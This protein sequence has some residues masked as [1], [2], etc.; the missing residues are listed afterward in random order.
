MS[1]K[2]AL[3]E[4]YTS[5]GASDGMTDERMSKIMAHGTDASKWNE[6]DIETQ[7]GRDAVF[8]MAKE[9][10]EALRKSTSGARGN[11]RTFCRWYDGRT[12]ADLVE[13][14]AATG[15]SE[16][17]AHFLFSSQ[18]GAVPRQ[19]LIA[20]LVDALAAIIGKQRP[21]P[22]TVSRGGNWTA[23]RVTEQLNDC[24]KATY[25]ESGIY[26]VAPD[27]VI[28]ALVCGTAA[29]RFERGNSRSFISTGDV[30]INAVRILPWQV[31]VDDNPGSPIDIPNEVF[32]DRLV[33]PMQL[34][35]EHPSLEEEILEID[36]RGSSGSRGDVIISEGWRMYMG[37]L[38]YVKFC[39]KVMFHCE[40]KKDSCIPV[41]FL[42]FQNPRSGF[43]G[44]SLTERV[45]GK[46]IRIDELE[47]FIAEMQRRHVRP[48]AF[49]DPNMGSLKMSKVA[50]LDMDTVELPGG[51][52]PTIHVPHVISP[53]LY[54]QI[55]RIVD[56]A[57]QETG[58]SDFSTQS[59]IPGGIETGPAVREVAFKNT[60][61]HNQFAMRYENL[62]MAA[63]KHIISGHIA[64]SKE[65]KGKHKVYFRRGAG[66]MEREW[67]DLTKDGIR[68]TV[69][70]EESA[71][72]TLSPSF[73]T[74]T[75]LG[76][77]QMGL[78]RGPAETRKLIANPD[79]EG[80]NK[81]SSSSHEDEAMFIIDE[82]SKGNR[83]VPDQFM[84]M[85]VIIPKV[86]SAMAL[87][88]Q[89]KVQQ[90]TPEIYALFVE[91]IDGAIRIE[92]G[93]AA[94]AQA[95][96]MPTD[97]GMPV[98]NVSRAAAQGLNA[99]LSGGGSSSDGI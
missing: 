51:R 10:I 13:N 84:E 59:K 55:D 57:M 72:D 1:K 52:P 16:R 90:E 8:S 9:R 60:E 76:W 98:A 92:E 97:E 67:P 69:F 85:N 81:Y 3:V 33:D 73:R 15:D 99:P 4:S 80:S 54:T 71:L 24:I 50:G 68:Y 6:P 75:V 14:G 62:F 77:A 44:V 18:T 49:V 17:D 83:I 43:Y 35:E 27:L 22:R 61:R 45:A 70:I 78:L 23:Q 66:L 47:K 32:I 34:I 91:F 36:R 42:R 19:N 29:L 96:S 41:E 11:M 82:I 53:E 48:T 79:L 5:K 40:K 56:R 2:L 39:D 20:T 25:P 95:G 38:T 93:K 64:I 63:A 12:P 31:Y 88:R 37:E 58:I 94:A 65:R 74:E 87:A 86:K 7:E 46:Q 28:D 89:Y 30:T 21:M 26:E